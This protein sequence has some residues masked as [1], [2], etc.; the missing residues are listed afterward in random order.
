M[1]KTLTTKIINKNGKRLGFMVA[2]KNEN[3]EVLL[4]FSLCRKKDKFNYDR[5]LHIATNRSF[6]GVTK[7]PHSLK[8]KVANFHGRCIKYFKDAAVPSMEMFTFVNT[9][10]ENEEKQG[11]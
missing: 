5:G 1:N 4:G 2:T 8:S 7:F 11:E 3:N 6:K 10:E 9:K